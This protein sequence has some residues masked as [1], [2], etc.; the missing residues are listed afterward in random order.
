MEK[1]DAGRVGRIMKSLLMFALTTVGGICFIYL[2]Q[3]GQ[4]ELNDQTA[5]MALDKQVIEDSILKTRCGGFMQG[6]NM[7]AVA[8]TSD[9][10]YP[11]ELTVDE[12][13]NMVAEKAARSG[14][15]GKFFPVRYKDGWLDYVEWPEECVG[16][17]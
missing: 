14:P 16:V 8:V 10:L 7:Q 3:V 11:A 1:N 4:R 15:D 5:V 17:L 12:R 9:S 6:A 13:M 2:M